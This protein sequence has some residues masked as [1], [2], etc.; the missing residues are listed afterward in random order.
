[1]YSHLTV[2][3]QMNSGSCKNVIFKPCLQIIYNMFK[4][5]LALN[6]LQ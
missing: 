4:N 5:D 6:D 2:R 3:K 1:M